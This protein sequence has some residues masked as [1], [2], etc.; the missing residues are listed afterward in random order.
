MVG[1]GKA[2]TRRERTFPRAPSRS[3]LIWWTW[4]SAHDAIDGARGDID[5]DLA[6]THDAV[7]TGHVSQADDVRRICTTRSQML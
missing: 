1:K 7:D 6:H 2:G 4:R 5:D 3:M